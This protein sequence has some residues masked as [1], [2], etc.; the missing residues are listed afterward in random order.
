MRSNHSNGK[1][2]RT[3]RALRLVLPLTAAL[4][5][6]AALLP[7]AGSAQSRAVPS[8]T[9]LPSILGTAV[10]HN[11][12]T[13]TNGAWSGSPTTFAYGWRRCPKDGG[14][15]DGS[16][17]TVLSSAT[18]SSYQV[19]T[20]D[21]AFTIRVRVTAS[22]TDGSASSLSSATSVVVAVGDKPASTHPHTIS[23]TSVVGQ[24]LTA[25]LGTWTG[26]TPISY[27]YQWRRCDTIG[28]SCSSITGAS[29]KT[30]VLKSVD[31]G[32]TLRISVTATNS[33]G[34][35]SATSVPTTVVSATPT[36]AATGCPA[37]AGPVQVADV[38]PPARLVI[39]KQKVSPSVLHR[40]SR[41][42]VVRYHISDTCGQTVIGA[43]VYATA[44]PFNQWSIPAEQPTGQ[45]GWAVLAMSRRVGYPISKVQQLLVIFTRARKPGEGLQAGISNQRLFAMPVNLH[46]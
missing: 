40:T 18:T 27:G 22:N 36:P 25:N 9:G 35:T 39:D 20:A 23:G 45:D 12:L 17:C 4:A 43:L 44:V 28:S 42:L 37:G 11:T 13:V 24:T 1:S 2:I 30:Y 5:L 3:Y 15:S 21:I 32:N 6:M 34:A 14:A 46:S 7:G 19:G 26:V 31:A 16:N 10:E 29:G 33:A 41:E 8:S 38:K